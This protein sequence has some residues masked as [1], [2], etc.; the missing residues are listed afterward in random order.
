[1]YRYIIVNVLLMSLY[2]QKYNHTTCLHV[3]VH[4]KAFVDYSAE[5]SEAKISALASL[6]SS[7]VKQVLS[8]SSAVPEHFNSLSMRLSVVAPLFNFDPRNQTCLRF[9]KQSS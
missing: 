6:A 5:S 3:R 9:S 2:C 1:M 8:V 4:L 7:T